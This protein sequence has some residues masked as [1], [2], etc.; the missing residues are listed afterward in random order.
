MHYFRSK[1]IHVGAI[2]IMIGLVAAVGFQTRSHESARAQVGH[3]HFVAA[4][5]NLRVNPRWDAATN[6]SITNLVWDAAPG[7]VSYNI[8]QYDEKIGSTSQTN[9]DMP[10]DKRNGNMSSAVTAVDASGVESMP[11]NIV[12]NVGAVDPKNPPTWTN[13]DAPHA[14]ILL[15]AKPD[16][17]L[18]KPRIVINWYK[19][20]SIYNIYRNGQKIASG[21]WGLVYVDNNVTPGT[22]YTYE[23]TAVK[24]FWPTLPESVKSNA[25]SAKALNSAPTLGSIKPKIT[26]VSA[27]DDSAIVYFEP[28]EGAA[29][30][31]IYKTSSPYSVKYAGKR[32]VKRDG[33]WGNNLPMEI[34]YGIEVNDIDLVNGNDLVLEAVD[35][36]GPFQKMDG[37]Y[38]PGHGHMMHTNGQGDPSNVPIVIARSD[39]F[40]VKAKPRTLTGAQAFFDTFRSDRQINR[41]PVSDPKLL[42]KFRDDDSGFGVAEFQNNNWIFRNYVADNHFTKLFIMNNHFMETLYDGPAAKG[43]FSHNNDSTMVMTAKKPVDISGGKVVHVTMEVDAHF[44]G[45]RW[46]EILLTPEGDTIV[47]PATVTGASNLPTLSGQELRWE[48]LGHDYSLSYVRGAGADGKVLVDSG[49]EWSGG[50]NGGRR[51]RGDG[52][53]LFNGSQQDIDKRHQFDLYVSKTKFAIYEEG[54]LIRE[55]DFPT[56]LAFE[57]MNVHF[58]HQVYHSSLERDEIKEYA[59]ITTYWPNY[60]PWADERHWD[61]MGFEV[62]D[63]F[64]TPSTPIIEPPVFVAPQGLDVKLLANK[65]TAKKGETIIYSLQLRNIGDKKQNN[66]KITNPLPLGTSYVTS[67]DSGT[68]TNGTIGWLINEIPVGGSKIVTLEVKVE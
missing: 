8:Y 37:A 16:W 26:G 9:F 30:Y 38:L 25:I 55:A 15:E 3:S 54:K 66:I 65:D 39:P 60:R 22:T 53:V 13:G 42:E 17:N 1:F 56:P 12:A 46:V 23:V 34:P 32:Y 51:T 14:P 50:F 28:V 29:D 27:N 36:L 6:K 45:R 11:S 35:K 40:H 43:A 63:T 59:P 10:V 61:N 58:S 24:S 49:L 5:Y 33:L 57:K 31:R 68:N 19:S 44:S 52:A 4:P 67:S 64:A 7:A 18:D 62:L 21:L 47:N 20:G 41:V 48:I 2:L